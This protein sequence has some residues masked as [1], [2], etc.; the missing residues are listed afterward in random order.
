MEKA[1]IPSLTDFG[2]PIGFA[3]KPSHRMPNGAIIIAE[4][5]TRSPDDPRFGDNSQR[6]SVV[7]ALTLSDATPFATWTRVVRNSMGPDPKAEDF[8]ET[9]HYHRSIVEAAKEFSNRAALEGE[10]YL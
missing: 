10:R 4:V 7:L 2:E 3:Y 9:G 8:C 1:M 6:E 5:I